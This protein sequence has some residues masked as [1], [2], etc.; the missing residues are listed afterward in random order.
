[1]FTLEMP[2]TGVWSTYTSGSLRRRSQ[3]TAGEWLSHEYTSA[4]SI[5]TSRAG[6]RSGSAAVPLTVDDNSVSAR[7]FAPSSCAIAPRNNAATSSVNAYSSESVSN[8]PTAPVVPFASARAAG[9][10]PA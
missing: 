3:S 2:A 7:P 6:S 5:G 10:G 1:M 8:T 4:P 9:S